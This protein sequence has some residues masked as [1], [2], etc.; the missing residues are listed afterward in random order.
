MHTDVPDDLDETNDLGILGLRFV[1]NKLES[2]EHG[3]RTKI[4]SDTGY[5]VGHLVTHAR[6][7]SYG[8]TIGLHLGQIDQLT[9]I[10]IPPKQILAHFIDCRADSPSLR[11]VVRIR[12]LSSMRR[13]LVIPAGV[14][15]TFQGIGNVL[16]RNDLV[17]YSSKD[18]DGWRIEDDLISMP[19]DIPLNKITPVV[20]NS[21]LVP[22]QVAL[23][24]YRLQS[25]L[26]RGGPLNQQE[27]ILI[28]AA[29]ISN[30][31]KIPGVEI[32]PSSFFRVADNSWGLLPTTN[33][34]I[35]HLVILHLSRNRVA[36][37][38][39]TGHAV[40][41]TFLH[42]ND[43]RV[44]LLIK[45]STE[46]PNHQDSIIQEINF[47]ERLQVCI[48]AGTVHGFRGEGDVLVKLEFE[49]KSSTMNEQPA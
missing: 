20:P 6:D 37:H 40:I 13:R 47:D 10:A 4:L 31:T 28:R 35:V 30:A 3:S 7:F 11:R 33:S 1:P 42:C 44:E 45:K 25:D 16:T 39:H 17:L 26:M 22:V 24:F 29:G 2:D 46:D 48:S 19:V 8:S 49:Q 9:F 38:S 18:G 32:R 12:F 41:Y 21:L 27:E 23:L 14:A 43:R 34:C 36:W 15:H 5:T